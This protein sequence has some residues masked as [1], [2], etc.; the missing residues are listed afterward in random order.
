MLGIE[1]IVV[2]RVGREVDGNGGSVVGMSGFMGSEGKGFEG[3]GG[4]VG[5]G[6]LV[7]PIGRVG[8]GGIVLGFGSVGIEGNG[9]IVGSVGLGSDGFWGNGNAG[10]GGGAPGVSN[11]WRAA[12]LVLG[13]SDDKAMIIDRM[14]KLLRKVMVDLLDMEIIKS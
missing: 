9:G 14:K 10:C 4:I 5:F 3:I 13:K 8:K 11:K 6:K 7:G 12:K 1:G 2:G